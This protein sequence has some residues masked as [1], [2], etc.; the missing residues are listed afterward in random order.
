MD[1][2][3]GELG[4]S[5]EELLQRI[6]HK[7][8]F[9]LVRGI[10]LDLCREFNLTAPSVK[11]ALES[12]PCDFTDAT[13]VRLNIEAAGD[14]D[15]KYHAR[16]VFGHYLAD[17]HGH[18]DSEGDAETQPYAEIVADI[19]VQMLEKRAGEALLPRA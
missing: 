9:L 13:E 2:A 17:L 12:D 3:A 8:R 19:I 1:N 16:H 14:I 10:F 7:D 4:L 5:S 6:K 11:E 18:L 15:P